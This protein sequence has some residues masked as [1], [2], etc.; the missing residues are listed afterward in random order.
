[1]VLA[2]TTES[3]GIGERRVCL[4]YC[5]EFVTGLVG[6]VQRLLSLGHTDTQRLIDGLT[7]SMVAAVDASEGRSLD[8]MGSFTPL[9]DLLSA[10]RE[11]ADRRLFVS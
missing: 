5:H 4:L 7:P 9:D 10:E 1:M 3:A 6:T 8:S 2:L 11:R